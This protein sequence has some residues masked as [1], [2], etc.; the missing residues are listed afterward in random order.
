MQSY[1]TRCGSIPTNSWSCNK[2]VRWRNT[3]GCWQSWPHIGWPSIQSGRTSTWSW[4]KVWNWALFRTNSAPSWKRRRDSEDTVWWENDQEWILVTILR[5]CLKSTVCGFEE[6]HWRNFTTLSDHDIRKGIKWY[7]SRNS[8]SFS[9]TDIRETNLISLW[10][11]KRFVWLTGR[12][13]I[14]L[15]A[16]FR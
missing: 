11:Q 12:S 3:S 16:V 14:I 15:R 9:G 2:Q 1:R 4:I 13:E 8:V 10:G 5:Q 7:F 6:K